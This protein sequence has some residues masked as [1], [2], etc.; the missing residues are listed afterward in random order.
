MQMQQCENKQRNL[1]SVVK[2]LEQLEALSELFLD[3][4]V[5]HDFSDTGAHSEKIVSLDESL[6]LEPWYTRIHI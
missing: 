6:H 2:F 4:H 5:G 1:G 3:V